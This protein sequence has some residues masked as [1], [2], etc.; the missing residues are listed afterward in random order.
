MAWVAYYTSLFQMR[1]DAL[2]VASVKDYR[3]ETED[4]KINQAM[5]SA[6][7]KGGALDT[8]SEELAGAESAV[9]AVSQ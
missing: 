7:E 5:L 4:T 8:L 9:G 6:Y 3:R 1:T 2:E